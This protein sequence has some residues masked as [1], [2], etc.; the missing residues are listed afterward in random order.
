MTAA[1]NTKSRR[2]PARRPRG[3]PYKHV[4][5]AKSVSLLG[6]G[7]VIGAVLGAGIALVVAPQS[8][9]ETRRILSRRAGSL[10]RGAGAWTKLGRELQRAARAKRRA[11]EF[12]AKRHQL[13]AHRAARGD[14]PIPAP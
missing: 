13:E 12:E 9:A 5:D 7:M 11:L 4:T 3:R 1:D 8:G 14:A 2:E 6:L 10:G